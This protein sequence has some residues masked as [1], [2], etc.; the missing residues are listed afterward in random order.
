MPFTDSIKLVDVIVAE[1]TALSATPSDVASG[2]EFIGSA[3]HVETGNL[4]VLDTHTSD[5]TINAGESY[6]V[7]YGINKLAYNV[8]AKSIG[9]QT[10]GTAVNTDI[11]SGKTAWVNGEKLTGNMQN[12]GAQVA[13]LAC[14]QE[15]IIPAG[16]HNGNGKISAKSLISQT[17]ASIMPNNILVGATCWA[18]GEMLTGTMP[19]VGKVT[20]T[21][22]AG[23]SYTIAEGYHN[24]TGKVTAND[25]ASQTPGTASTL[26]IVSGKTAWVNGVKVT[27]SMNSNEAQT[28]TLPI[29]GTYEIPNGYHTG[30]GKIVQNVPS[31]EGQTVAPAKTQQTLEVAGN[32]MTGNIVITGVDALNYGRFLG[33]VKDSTGTNISNYVLS[34]SGNQATIAIYVDNWHDMSTINLYQL[35]F[36]NL[37]DSSSNEVTLD[38][39]IFIDSMNPSGDYKFGNIVISTSIDFD[40]GG[41]IITIKNINSGKLTMSEDFHARDFGIN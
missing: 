1:Q 18:N 21:L 16:Y 3:K 37:V 27:G 24:G 29:N 38:C 36:A 10:P 33:V 20:K 35:T 22:A 28:I 23:E 8:K 6:N 26:E 31:K 2:K 34:V 15:F 19:N 14:S 12:H 4:P 41:Q 5:V 11:L 40:T 7:A 30:F 17:F 25:L 32:Y 39:Q 9:D 13:E